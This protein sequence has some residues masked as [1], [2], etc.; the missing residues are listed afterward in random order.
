MFVAWVKRNNPVGKTI[1]RNT[2]LSRLAEIIRNDP[3]WFFD[4]SNK[5]KITIG[6]RCDLPE[7]LIIEYDLQGWM[8]KTYK[9]FN[10]AQRLKTQLPDRAYGAVRILPP[11]DIDETQDD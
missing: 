7:R 6:N 2:F 5:K 10:E 4:A 3:D 1:G 11:V 9:G 8:N